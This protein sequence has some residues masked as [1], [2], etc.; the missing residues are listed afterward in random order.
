CQSAVDGPRVPPPRFATFPFPPA[1]LLKLH[2][3][4]PQAALR[5]NQRSSQ[6][7]SL[8]RLEENSARALVPPALPAPPVGVVNEGI[9][10]ESFRTSGSLHSSRPA[11]LSGVSLRANTRPGS[12][13]SRCTFRAKTRVF[14][15]PNA[16]T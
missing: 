7:R 4:E 10:S 1:H 13:G 8:E 14:V 5:P 12:I 6:S 2:A 16:C 11:D 3:S 15:T 9:S